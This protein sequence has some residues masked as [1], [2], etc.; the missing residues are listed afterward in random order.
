MVKVENLLWK[1]EFI[2]R[3]FE[4]DMNARATIQTIC[5]YLQEGAVNHARHLKVDK[6]SIGDFNVTWVLSRLNVKMERYPMWKEKVVVETWPV[7]K[8]HLFAIRDYQL[9]DKKGDSLGVG[10]ASWM[11]IDLDTRK[12]VPMP[13]FMDGMENQQRGRALSVAFNRLPALDNVDAEKFFNVRHSDL[14]INQHVNYVNYIEWA[15]EA[16]PREVLKIN[17][18]TEVAVSFRAES[19]YGDR[20][21]S[22]VQQRQ[23]NE[24]LHS[25]IREEDGT[26]LTRLVT[27]WQKVP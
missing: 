14:D 19:Y 9:F 1:E 8:D 25:L 13:P 24:Y 22:Q 11:L 23:E 4:M 10:T 7:L 20:V 16:I 26:E 12:P 2:I 6:D 5:R 15:L 21:I 3:S 27:R 17:Q 18:L